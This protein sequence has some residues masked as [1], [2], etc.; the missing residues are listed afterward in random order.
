LAGTLFV[1]ALWSSGQPILI[2]DRVPV[3]KQWIAECTASHPNCTLSRPF[4][5]SPAR[6]IEVLPTIRLVEVGDEKPLR[7]ITLSHCWGGVDIPG[8]T[9]LANIH[10][11]RNEI[12]FDILPKTFQ[13]AITVTRLLGVPYL[14]VDCLCIVQDDVLDWEKEASKMASVFENGVCTITAAS[15]ENCHVGLGISEPL[16]PAAQ[17]ELPNP[18]RTTISKFSARQPGELRNPWDHHPHS[19]LH[20]RGW[21]MQEIILSRRIIHFLDGRFLWQCHTRMESEDGEFTAHEANPH[22][23]NLNSGPLQSLLPA[24]ETDF[25]AMWWSTVTDYTKRQLTYPSDNMAAFSG[26]T[27]FFAAMSADEPVLGLWRANLPY[28]LAWHA[29]AAE[30][31]AQRSARAP[32]WSWFSLGHAQATVERAPHLDRRLRFA[33]V[34]EVR[35]VDVAWSGEPLTSAVVR[36][37][38]ALRTRLARL[39]RIARG[40]MRDFAVGGWA[41]PQVLLAPDPTVDW[42]PEATTF[43]AALLFVQSNGRRDGSAAGPWRVGYLVVEPTGLGKGEFRRIGMAVVTGFPPDDPDDVVVQR[44]LQNMSREV[45]MTLV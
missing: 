12:A 1:R 41:R 22:R 33:H 44:L 4:T 34:A 36:G 38:V 45:D 21:I 20:K 35:A 11:Y 27:K 13:E 14:W 7:Y 10:E 18:S 2:D 42:Q 32:S 43:Q 31:A 23:V 19:L 5:T 17:F 40:N 30:H 39:T 26:I 37:A 15:A 24:N 6:L 16:P 3:I 29:S 28:H 9:T 25:S 8:K